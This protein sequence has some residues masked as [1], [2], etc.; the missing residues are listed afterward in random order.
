M[1]VNIHM[2]THTHPFHLKAKINP[3]ASCWLFDHSNEE[4]NAE[5]GH[6]ERLHCCGRPDYGLELVC[7]K[8]M[9]SLEIRAREPVAC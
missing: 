8:N 2:L 7:R 5:D 6:L 4:N 1:H 3:L 9:E